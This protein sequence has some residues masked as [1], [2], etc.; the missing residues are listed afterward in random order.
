M[1]KILWKWL[2]VAFIVTVLSGL[3][4]L[5]AQQTVRQAAN[6]PQIQIAEDVSESLKQGADPTMLGEP[7]MDIAQSLSPYV[8]IYDADG[9]PIANTGTLDDQA[10]QIPTGLFDQ[11]KKDGRAIV[12]WQPK[13]D[14]RQAIVVTSFTQE[15]G[16][17]FVMVGRSLREVELRE[18]QLLKLT[19]TVWLFL[20]VTT[21]FW[22]W[23]YHTYIK[24]RL[25]KHA[26]TEE[27]K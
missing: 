25:K 2:F 15:K 8:V 11:V 12:T 20:L 17:G 9:K 26:V 10:P 1:K 3:S 14:V 13:A 23:L 21:L 4:F 27:V 6:D 7:S 18:H 16:S 19:F 5:L 24:P 22:I